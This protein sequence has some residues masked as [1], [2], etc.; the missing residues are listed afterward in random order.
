MIAHAGLPTRS[1]PGAE[2]D[3]LRPEDDRLELVLFAE[4]P[5]IVTPIG[6]AVD[7][8]DRLF[9][10]ESHT[11]ERPRDYVGPPSDRV[12]I[13]EDRDG[14]GKADRSW[15]FAEGLN[16]AMNLAFSPDGLLYV[17]C[18]RSV[19]ALHD[20]DGDGTCD[21]QETVLTL[22]TRERYSH[23]CLL[24]ITFSDDGWMY[25]GRG[26]T[27]GR[28]WTLRGTDG[29]HVSGYGDG[30]NIMRC[31]PDGSGVEEFATGFWNP[32]DIKF[33]HAGRL[34]CVDNDPDARGPN[35]L[36]HVVAGG[37]YGYRSL[38]GGGGNHPY[39]G[40][41]GDLPG[42]LSYISGT[43]EAP[44]GLI[45]CRFA[46]LPAE[47]QD[48]VLITVWNENTIERHRLQS[49]GASL[50]GERSVLVRG[51]KEFRPVAVAADSKGNLYITDWVLVAYPNH[52]RGRIW[53]LSAT[54]DT[55]TVGP[56][57]LVSRDESAERN[58][59]ED[60]TP[61]ADALATDDPFAHHA[62]VMRLAGEDL[63]ES[64]L[65][66]TQ[67]DD[68][69]VRLGTLLALKRRGMHDEAVIRSLLGDADSR[70]R[71]ATL[72]W[73]GEAG[74]TGLRSEIEMALQQPDTTG[75][76]VETY[77]ATLP[78]LDEDFIAGLRSR[79]ADHARSLLPNVDDAVLRKVV[80][81]DSLA[82]DARALVLK[83]LDV[84]G[85]DAEWLTD[86]MS[87][88]AQAISVRRAA[89]NRLGRLSAPDA[90][91]A[92]WQIA[93]N[94]SE[95]EQLRADA[96]AQIA[97]TLSADVSRLLK[98]LDDDDPHVQ[99]AG[100]RAVRLATLSTADKAAVRQRLGAARASHGSGSVRE[101][102]AMA[103]GEPIS[104]PAGLSEWQ[105]A[106]ADGGVPEAGRRVFHSPIATCSKCHAIDGLGGTLGPSLA[107]VAQ[108]LS[109]EQILRAILRPSDEFPPQYQAWSITTTDGRTHLG[110]QI[111]H[112]AHGDIELRTTDDV[113]RHFEAE[114][115]ADYA[116]SSMS[117]MPS[118]LEKSLTV[119]ELRDLVAFLATLQ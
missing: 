72:I 86:L 97:R 55:Q 103:V 111:D 74:L 95:D 107:N 87:S 9:V 36:V 101:A 42:T 90:T 6:A 20:D 10:V 7:D 24:G 89:A 49:R 4:D 12:K 71:R 84:R 46:R 92:L 112:K 77:I 39:Q 88:D 57:E 19:V 26:N 98:L 69:R 51:D 23:N 114:Q 109:R 30:G 70:V 99:L 22:E 31:R 56:L 80:R 116:A 37:D 21:R 44:S 110:L 27:A 8:R 85:D 93:E 53:R 50:A 115:I 25:V 100:A 29:S 113:V 41:D 83:R 104:R 54:P 3:S 102:L 79:R 38:F 64:H 15:V 47:Y 68:P 33:D 117:I 119:S 108:S 61:V 105:A 2:L 96:V 48:S 59:P 91:R 18:A 11:H 65:S 16:A 76:L 40:W 60:H 75:V 35:R 14:D 78:L 67:H 118:G 43:G 32:F 34:L 81:N 45:N 63:D 73:V 58:Q 1:T 94:P 5:D 106:L 17:V 13:F 82:A 52:G 66:L 28:A 62:A